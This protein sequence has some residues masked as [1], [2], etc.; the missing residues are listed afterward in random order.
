[1]AGL[2][3]LKMSATT[4]PEAAVLQLALVGGSSKLSLEGPLRC[5]ALG[6]ASGLSEERT[7]IEKDLQ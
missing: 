4:E 3:W 7:R 2:C 6:R 1:M 5:A